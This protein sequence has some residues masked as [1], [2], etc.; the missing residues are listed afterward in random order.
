M[1]RPLALIALL[2][3]P[4]AAQDTLPSQP[5]EGPAR[6]R[7]ASVDAAWIAGAAALDLSASRYGLSQCARC[8]EA[9]PVMRSTGG[10]VAMKLAATGIGVA[11]AD[12]LRRKGDRR[13]AKIVRWTLVGLQVALA[14]NALAHAHR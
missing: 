5:I 10:A 9:N 11:W 1:Y 6:L 8:Y 14:G 13:G 2:A 7:A 4:C 12:H 3:L